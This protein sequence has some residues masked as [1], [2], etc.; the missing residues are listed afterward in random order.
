MIED[1]AIEKLRRQQKAI[2]DFGS[3]ALHEKDLVF[4]L[5]EAA[6]VCA[7]GLGTRY[8]KICRYRPI[9]NDLLIEIGYGWHPGV[10]GHVISKA[11]ESSPQ[12]RA[13]TTGMP[14]ICEDIRKDTG[15]TLPSFYHDHGIISTIDILIPGTEHPY[16][17]IEIDS[18]ILIRFDQQDIIYLTGFANV[19]AEAI[20]A[21]KQ[22]ESAKLFQ[23]NEI[24][25]K[26]KAIKSQL[27]AELA[28]RSVKQRNTFI[29]TMSHELR[30]PLNAIVGFINLLSKTALD[31]DQIKYISILQNNAYHLRSIINDILDFARIESG[32]V[33]LSKAPFSIREF[34]SEVAMTTRALIADRSISVEEN[35]DDELFTIYY[36]D[37]I[38][39]RQILLN[40]L[41]NAVKFTKHGS[42][43]IRVKLASKLTGTHIIR[44]EVQ[45]T[46][47]GIAPDLH[48]SIFNFYER[49]ET[50]DHET[51]FGSGLGL[52]ISRAIVHLMDGEIGLQSQPGEGSTFWF[53]IPLEETASLSTLLHIPNTNKSV[54][55]S[56]KLNI[57]L[58][59]DSEPSRMLLEIILQNLGHDIVACENGAE[60]VKAASS[61]RFDLIILDLQMP[62][63]GGI[64]AAKIIRTLNES[65][66]SK[67]I[68]ALTAS[69]IPETQ[70]EATDAGID[71]IITK[72]FNEDELEAILKNI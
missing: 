56:R 11:D 66:G 26:E 17:V 14:A 37:L 48:D 12:G 35:V 10:I 23:Q 58:A 72:P 1:I 22:R 47:I 59:E 28:Q 30:T 62:I 18:D 46:G 64:Q 42:I 51:G 44:F 39:I 40:I 61:R 19:L 20:A 60:A 69:S 70:K 50:N 5:N 24:L 41:G 33:T 32:K 31:S 27:E 8:A 55:K 65:V 36:G 25:L 68:I 49:A 57:L 53:E 6:R 45:D 13:F 16:G 43:I 67:N 9:E 21:A 38:R 63:M 4:L 3:L 7:L 15:F 34:I 2:A 54:Y 29:A 52:A 71:L